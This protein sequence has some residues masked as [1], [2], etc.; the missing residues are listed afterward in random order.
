MREQK[1]E[2]KAAGNA[3]AVPTHTHSRARIENEGRKN[4]RKSTRR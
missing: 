3:K 4:E 1:Y 2:T